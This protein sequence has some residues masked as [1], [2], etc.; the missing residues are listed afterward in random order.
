MSKVLV[1]CEVA[2]GSIKNV[3]LELL[4]AAKNSNNDFSAVLLGPSAEAVVDEAAHYGASEVL[5]C[6]NETLA[7]YNPETF[8]KAI[9]TA[10][11]K[12]QAKFILASSTTLSRDLFPKVAA[13]LNTGIVSDCTFLDFKDNNLK[14]QKPLYAG[15]CNA[16]VEFTNSPIQIVLMRPNQLPVNK[17]DTSLSAN[18]Q[19]FDIDTPES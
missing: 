3:S 12:C 4:S 6:N 2:N 15:K 10:V 18:K 7:G 17:A 1:F 14:T 8:S 9:L 19:S 5:I 16:E 13:E 11:E